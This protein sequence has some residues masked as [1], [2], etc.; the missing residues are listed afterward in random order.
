[1]NSPQGYTPSWAT[2]LNWE[3]MFE[4]NYPQRSKKKKRKVKE[5]EKEKSLM[6]DDF[7]FQDF[8]N[9]ALLNCESCAWSVPKEE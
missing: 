9:G 7:T 8:A 5:M 6:R 2:W 4:E 3:E 1:M